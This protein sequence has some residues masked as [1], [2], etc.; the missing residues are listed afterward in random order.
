MMRPS[1]LKFAV[2]CLRKTLKLISF[3]S[4]LGLT[5]IRYSRYLIFIFTRFMI[6]IVKTGLGENN[7]NF[8]YTS[9]SK[10]S[11]F[12]WC[13]N[14]ESF[15]LTLTTR[16]FTP[17]TFWNYNLKVLHILCIV[18]FRNFSTLAKSTPFLWGLGVK[19]S[20]Y[21]SSDGGGRKVFSPPRS[22]HATEQIRSEITKRSNPKNYFSPPFGASTATDFKIY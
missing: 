20:L 22:Q 12:M 13:L 17:P 2:Q 5:S 11:L 18:L 21:S 16:F 4:R 9:T 6:A 15:F 14:L 7:L 19:T 8:M 3:V 10:S 1:R